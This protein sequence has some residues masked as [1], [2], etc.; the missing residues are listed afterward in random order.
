MWFRECASI[1]KAVCLTVVLL[2]IDRKYQIVK[3]MI[4]INTTTWK[5]N[6]MDSL[7]HGSWC[8]FIHRT[9]W[10][11]SLTWMFYMEFVY[12]ILET[13]GRYD[14]Q[15]I[16]LHELMNAYENPGSRRAIWNI[17][18]T[19][20]T[21][22][23]RAIQG[24]GFIPVGSTFFWRWKICPKST[25][26]IYFELFF[27]TMDKNIWTFDG[28]YLVMYGYL[29]LYCIKATWAFYGDR[30]SLWVFVLCTKLA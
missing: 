1:C 23:P 3:E 25:L 28:S 6:T 9:D 5:K 20:Y 15:Y 18:V 27:I 11:T 26:D 8:Y 12:H 21:F 10:S 13:N 22:H 2:P 14:W 16:R 17:C 4:M 7:I 19:S 29:S 24:H 30:N